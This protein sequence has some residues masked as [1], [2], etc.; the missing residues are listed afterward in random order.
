MLILLYSII[1][2]EQQSE[3]NIQVV[4]FVHKRDENIKEVNP[5]DILL[6]G[7]TFFLREN[8]DTFS[9][10]EM[11]SGYDFYELYDNTHNYD[12][13]QYIKNFTG[14]ER[15]YMNVIFNISLFKNHV[16]N[17]VERRNYVVAEERLTPQEKEFYAKYCQCYVCQ[18][19]SYNPLK[20]VSCRHCYGCIKTDGIS[21]Y[22]I[23]KTREYIKKN[24]LK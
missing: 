14:E 12:H 13:T 7:S 22:A 18:M 2:M 9:E 8:I 10:T 19:S 6:F 1:K 11:F 5:V 17:V 20:Y 3:D 15:Q 24:N 21:Q 16:E 23:N 4:N